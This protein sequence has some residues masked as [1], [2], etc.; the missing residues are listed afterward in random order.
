[1]KPNSFMHQSTLDI[2][3]DADKNKFINVI[4]KLINLINFF[5]S[6]IL[7]IFIIL[8]ESL[9][10]KKINNSNFLKKIIQRIKDALFLALRP[11]LIPLMLIKF[12]I[13]IKH[14]YVIVFICLKFLTN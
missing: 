13:M 6:K 12:Q 5:L 1:M 11:H 14:L 4:W 9:N 8:Y 2:V 10:I 7:T 3:Y